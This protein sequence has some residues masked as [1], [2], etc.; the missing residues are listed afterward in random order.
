LIA[1]REARANRDR[2][3]GRELAET[4]IFGM[5]QL[6][7]GQ[8]VAERQTVMY[9]IKA[10]ADSYRDGLVVQAKYQCGS[11]VLLH[12]IDPWSLKGTPIECGVI[13]N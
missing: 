9:E 4:L 8:P 13:G 5:R 2:G 10:S 11:I 7:E 3:R 6:V 12:G 1:G